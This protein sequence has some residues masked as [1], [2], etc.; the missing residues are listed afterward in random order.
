MSRNLFAFFLSELKIV[1]IIC[2]H[3]SAVLEVTT[4]QLDARFNDDPKCGACGKSYGLKI[5]T[6]N[7]LANLGKALAQ[8][9]IVSEN[10]KI[11]QLEFILPAPSDT[12]KK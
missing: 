2:P 3:C 9:K 6:D 11:P 12:G 5:G 7:I 8:F 1:R 4:E 10:T